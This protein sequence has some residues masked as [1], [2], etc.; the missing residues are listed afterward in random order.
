MTAEENRIF[1][2]GVRVRG[3]TSFKLSPRLN[4][5][6]AGTRSA[7]SES[8]YPACVRSTSDPSLRVSPVLQKVLTEQDTVERSHR[9]KS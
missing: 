6:R 7:E 8:D 9:K 5:N 2:L 4:R 3:V 1:R